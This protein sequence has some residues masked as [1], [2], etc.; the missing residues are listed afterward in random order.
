MVE[1]SA[2]TSFTTEFT[3]VLY[4]PHC[5]SCRIIMTFS[6]RIPDGTFF[7]WGDI[8]PKWWKGQVYKK[9]TKWLHWTDYHWNVLPFNPRIANIVGGKLT[10]N[11]WKYPWG[12]GYR[13]VHPE[14]TRY[15]PYIPSIIICP[16][17]AIKWPD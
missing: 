5:W 15:P 11:M 6:G 12:G 16:P 2:L 4:T 10:A 3:P 7:Y 9:G 8:Y 17:V 14:V 13:W 1:R